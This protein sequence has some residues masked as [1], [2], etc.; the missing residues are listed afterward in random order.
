MNRTMIVKHTA[1]RRGNPL[2]CVHNLPG[3]GAEFSAGQL[4]RLARALETIA[5]EC[6]QGAG[7]AYPETALYDLEAESENPFV[8]YRDQITGGYST[9]HRLAAL[10]L[11]LYNGAAFAV[12]LDTLLSSADEKHARIALELLAWYARHGENCPEFMALAGQLAYEALRTQ[13]RNT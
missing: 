11:N 4:R 9:A 3:E 10:V 8:A 6:D 7:L 5:D 13:R 2:A 12:R 1:D